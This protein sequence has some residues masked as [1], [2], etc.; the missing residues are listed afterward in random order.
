MARLVLPIFL[1]ISLTLLHQGYSH[2]SRTRKAVPSP[3][4][5]KSHHT[6]YTKLQWLYYVFSVHFL[7]DMPACLSV[8]LWRCSD[9]WGWCKVAAGEAVAGGELP[10]GDLG[11]A[12]RYAELASLCA[13]TECCFMARKVSKREC[14]SWGNVAVTHA[15]LAVTV[16]F[17]WVRQVHTVCTFGTCTLGEKKWCYL[18]HKR[19]IRL[20][21]QENP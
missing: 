16:C 15:D 9:R 18:E 11:S 5:G 13:H 6:H 20:S 8:F 21:P 10:E 3:Q 7:S 17:L 1:V 19:V 14:F 2:P 4:R 12:D